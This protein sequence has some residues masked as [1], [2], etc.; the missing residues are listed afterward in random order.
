GPVHAVDELHERALARTVLAQQGVDLT[1]ADIEV[2]AVVG[3]HVAEATGDVAHREQRLAFGG[4]YDRRR[5]RKGHA[6]IASF[7]LAIRAR[8]RV[9]RSSTTAMDSPRWR[10]KRATASG[11]SPE[12]TASTMPRCWAT[13]LRT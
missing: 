11:R 4:A 10:P 6:R 12:R 8:A 2:D 3:H 1:G 13:V 7:R 5:R 9:A